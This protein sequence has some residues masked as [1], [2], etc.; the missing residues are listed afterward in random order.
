[1]FSVPPELQRAIDGAQ[2]MLDHGL[3]VKTE[4]VEPLLTVVRDLIAQVES[5]QEIWWCELQPLNPVC[6][7]GKKWFS[8]VVAEWHKD[9]RWKYLIDAFVQ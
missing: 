2:G 5:R 6:E 4:Y 9:C 1:M 7:P 3:L 8:P